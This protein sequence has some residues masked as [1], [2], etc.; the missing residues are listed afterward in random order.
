M[1]DGVAATRFA[2]ELVSAVEVAVVVQMSLAL[3][4]VMLQTG[5]GM[6]RRVQYPK[7]IAPYE[8]GK[9]CGCI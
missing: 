2:V 8:T 1:L 4:T 7:G 9:R 3:K 5:I 6:H